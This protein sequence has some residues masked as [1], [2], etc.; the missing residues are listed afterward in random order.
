MGSPGD[1]V[2][3]TLTGMIDEE[4]EPEPAAEFRRLPPRVT[5]LVPPLEVRSVGPEDT[6]WQL[7][8]GGAG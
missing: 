7:R 6:E 2:S 8:A 3:S 1:R 5:A 4:P